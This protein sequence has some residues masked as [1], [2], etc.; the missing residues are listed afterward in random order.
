MLLY[1]EQIQLRNITP[2][3]MRY[4]ETTESWMDINTNFINDT[5]YEI[6]K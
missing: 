2:E 3:N 6:Q 5:K 4:C 1:T